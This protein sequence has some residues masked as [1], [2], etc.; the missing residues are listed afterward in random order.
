MR[1]GGD[2][3]M[4]V[5][6]GTGMR[7][8]MCPFI[9]VVGVY[10]RVGPVCTDMC[11]D[12]HRNWGNRDAQGEA[13]EEPWSGR[14]PPTCKLLRQVLCRGNGVDLHIDNKF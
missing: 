8:S 9:W 4:R 10:V 3:G 6:V 7:A 12:T 2:T 11:R 5:G 1:V 13:G 14:G